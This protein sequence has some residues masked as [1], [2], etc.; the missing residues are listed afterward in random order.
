[1]SKKKHTF[2]N[3]NDEPTALATDSGRAWPILEGKDAERF[4]R[5]MEDNERKAKEKAK[6]PMTKE[7]AETALIH[8]KIIH[9]LEKSNLEKLEEEIKRLENIVNGE[10]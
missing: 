2:A 6:R 1:M 4:L 10:K 3:E 8:K 5:I 9:E 7:E